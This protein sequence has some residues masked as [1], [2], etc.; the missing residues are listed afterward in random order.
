MLLLARQLCKSTLINY[1]GLNQY[2]SDGLEGRIKGCLVKPFRE[3]ELCKYSIIHAGRYL[4][5]FHRD[6]VL[7]SSGLRLYSYNILILN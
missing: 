2:L 7:L 4:Y 5:Y 6:C 1:T 3:D